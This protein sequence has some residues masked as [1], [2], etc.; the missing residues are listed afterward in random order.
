MKIFQCQSC[1]QVVYFENSQCLN[2]GHA[3]GY[4][5]ET[6][7]LSALEPAGNGRWRPLAAPDRLFRYCA[8]AAEGA[9]NW[10]IPANSDASLC[11]ACEL[12]RTIPDLSVPGNRERWRRIEL[13]KHKVIYAILRWGLPLRPMR[14]D[15]DGGLA[16]DFVAEGASAF[17]QEPVRTGHDNGLI[18]LNIAE[19][20]D[21][22]RERRRSELAEPYR[23]VI[24][25]LRHEIGHY[26]EQILVVNERMQPCRVLFGDERQDYGEALQRHY[27]QGPAPDW[28]SRCVSAYASSHPWEDFAETWGH[29]LHIVDALETAAYFGIRVT[30]RVGGD[31]ALATRVNFDAYA[32][33]PF[34]QLMETWLPLTYA[35]NALNR[36]VGQPDFY[37]FVLPAPAVDKLAFVHALVHGEPVG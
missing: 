17:G 18:T 5:P 3:L 13:A 36:S 1:G 24:G 11:Q 4:L 10:L 27:A 21:A 37:P 14:Q 26:Y 22:E 25:H 16:F 31:S 20:D 9:C 8:N 6:G 30:P 35:L 7:M 33:A 34:Q 19:A 12:N 15:G 28:S 32:P 23:T 2:C 29:Y